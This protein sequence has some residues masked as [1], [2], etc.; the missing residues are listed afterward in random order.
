MLN[1]VH[2]VFTGIRQHSVEVLSKSVTFFGFFYIFTSYIMCVLL[3]NF[4][5]MARNVITV[6]YCCI[7]N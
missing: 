2:K 3:Q 1:Q 6:M 4:T 5:D 7:I